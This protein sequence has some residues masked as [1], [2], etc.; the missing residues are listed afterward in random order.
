MRMDRQLGMTTQ[1]DHA[2]QP[3]RVETRHDTGTA[4]LNQEVMPPT[5]VIYLPGHVK[6][7]PLSEDD[8]GSINFTTPFVIE[9]AAYNFQLTVT[10]GNGEIGTD[11]YSVNVSHCLYV[12]SVLLEATRQS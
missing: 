12:R 10:D 3:D 7:K 9:E 6:R 11:Q 4:K 2:R 1:R 5:Q 8:T